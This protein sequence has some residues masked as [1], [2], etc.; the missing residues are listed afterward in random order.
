LQCATRALAREAG[1]GLYNN[2][3]KLERLLDQRV[4]CSFADG[5]WQRVSLF[6]MATLNDEE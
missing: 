6:G 1:S 3:L 2:N 5:M 4:E